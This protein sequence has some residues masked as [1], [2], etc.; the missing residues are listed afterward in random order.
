MTT[1]IIEVED[2]DAILHDVRTQTIHLDFYR[3]LAAML[4]ERKPENISDEQRQT[5]KL[6]LFNMK[7]KNIQAVNSL[8]QELPIPREYIEKHRNN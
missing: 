4:F 2:W 8:M 3:L 5:A 1:D 7:Y 6:I